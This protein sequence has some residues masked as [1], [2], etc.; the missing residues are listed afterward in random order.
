[1]I[2]YTFLECQKM[3]QMHQ[4]TL[5]LKIQVP[6]CTFS[7]PKKKF[8]RNLRDF[9]HNKFALVQQVLCGDQYSVN[10][11]YHKR[12]SK[13]IFHKRNSVQ[14]LEWTLDIK[15]ECALHS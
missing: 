1:M 15:M 8:S 4:K 11:K 9:L 10:I 12:I 5:V 6:F 14:A 13:R 3:H 2:K 7:N